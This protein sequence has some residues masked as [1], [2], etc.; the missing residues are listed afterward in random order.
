M[1]RSTLSAAPFRNWRRRWLKLWNLNK[2]R[3]MKSTSSSDQAADNQNDC[4]LQ[5]CHAFRKLLNWISRTLQFVLLNHWIGRV[6]RREC[7]GV[8]RRKRSSSP[9]DVLCSMNIS[10]ELPDF[11]TPNWHQFCFVSSFCSKPVTNWSSYLLCRSVRSV[12]RETRFLLFN[13]SFDY[14]RISTCVND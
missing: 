10:Q 5:I 9:R 12:P 7:G 13:L 4:E 6:E 11:L 1:K 2:F 14:H 8:R 3:R